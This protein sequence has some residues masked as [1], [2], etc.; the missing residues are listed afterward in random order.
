[1]AHRA[2]NHF[3]AHFMAAPDNP[4]LAVAMACFSAIYKKALTSK[5]DE[6]KELKKQ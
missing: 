4:S 1:M 5:N 6:K 2:N 3:L